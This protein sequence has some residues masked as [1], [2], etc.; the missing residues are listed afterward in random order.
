MTTR[1]EPTTTAPELGDMS[2][3]I[4]G[5]HVAAA[6]GQTFDVIDPA[7]GTLLARAPL[8]GKEDVDRAVAAAQRALDDP[9]GF[10]SWS[11]AKRGRTL[12]KLSNLVK[13]HIEEL[14]R[15]ESR[16]HATVSGIARRI[17][18]AGNQHVVADLEPAHIIVCQRRPKA[19][20]RF[21]DAFDGHRSYSLASGISRLAVM[22]SGDRETIM[23]TSSTSLAL[24][25]WCG[26]KGGT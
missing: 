22:F 20:L 10:S 2:M 4:G 8:G 16:N 9:K 17:D 14:A 19:Y 12:Q 11:A 7:S 18:S 23:A 25:S 1:T 3:I 5:E 26:R 15:L 13:E 21:A 6:D 24:I